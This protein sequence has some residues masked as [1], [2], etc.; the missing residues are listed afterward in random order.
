[1]ADYSIDLG[2]DADATQ[3]QDGTF[4]LEINLCRG[5]LTSGGGVTNGFV[6]SELA[7]F[8]EIESGDTIIFRIF[9]ITGIGGNPAHNV[10]AISGNISPAF[11]LDPEATGN[12]PEIPFPLLSSVLSNGSTF[13]GASSQLCLSFAP[14]PDTSWP[15][16]FQLANSTT[17]ALRTNEVATVTGPASYQMS[18]N[19][20]ITRSGSTVTYTTSD[21]EMVVSPD[22]GR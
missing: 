7:Q 15:C 4:P 9:N 1:M 2:V 6:P 3:N 13:S 14:E 22:S 21:P 18:I 11:T 8:D 5:E 12:P 19:L 17:G 16:L 20:S 10:T